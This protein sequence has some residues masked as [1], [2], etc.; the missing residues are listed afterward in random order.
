MILGER[1]LAPNSAHRDGVLEG[2]LERVEGLGLEL[3]P[4]QEE[5]ILELL[6]DHH[7]ILGTPTG[8][9]KSLVALALHFKALC[10]GQRSIYTAPTKALVAEK[11]FALSDELGAE[12]VG[13][14]TGDISL[15]RDAPVICATTEVLAN[16]VLRGAEEGRFPYVVLDEFHF[17]GDRER[18]VWW[19]IPLLA[20]PAATFLLL[21]A[22]LG[23]PTPLA[24]WL[25]SHTQRSVAAIV[26]T[27]RPVPLDFSYRETLLHE[28]VESLLEQSLD[29]I[30]LVCFTQ[31]A[32]AERA[33]ALTSARIGSRE[34]RKR[35]EAACGD[36]RFDTP[37]GRELRRLLGHGIGVHPAGLLPRY[38]LLV[39]QLAQ[40]GLLRVICGTDTLGVG[41]NI[42]IRTVLFSGL[43]K[44]DGEKITLLRARDFH[45]IAGR[46]GRKGFDEQG[47]VV[48]QAPEHV[49]WNRRAERKALGAGRRRKAR[50]KR[51][52]P[53]Q[54]VWNEKTFRSLVRRSPEPVVSH[55]RVT[56]GMLISLLQREAAE[57]GVAQGYRA[58][59]ELI[60]LSHGDARSRSR[61]LRDAADVFR[62]LLQAGILER[63]RDP[64]TGRRRVALDPG[65]QRN[66]S[67]HHALSLYLVE[68]VSALDPET[69]EYPLDVLSLI[70]A[71]LPDPRPILIQ[72]EKKARARKIAEL[73]AQRVPYHERL[74]Q[75]A[76]IHYPRPLED[77][78]EPTFETFARHHPW[79]RHENIHPKSVAREMFERY[80][81][82]EGYVR[83]YGLARSE[84]VLLRYLGQVYHALTRNV[85][86]GARSDSLLDVIRYFRT[87]LERIDASLLAE[88]HQVL[89][90]TRPDLV[91]ELEAPAESDLERDARTP[92]VRIRAEL[93]R[94]VAA[95]AARDW[96]A[97]AS[98]VRSDAP[99]PWSP[100]RFERALEPY[101]A[102]YS[103]I[104]FTPAARQPHRTEIRELGPGRWRVQQVLLDPAGD[105][106]WCIRGEVESAS[107]ADGTE[108]LLTL[109]AIGV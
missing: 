48:C 65:L 36:F 61:L 90:G 79:V 50:K 26:S 3:Y 33:Q 18:G 87:L 34:L 8:S 32:C 16:L 88:W 100:A 7:V 73:K 11:F 101:F 4:A 66:F 71:I 109:H 19:Q 23:D 21:S 72:Q 10:E 30:Y 39:E 43:S 63:K 97:A 31:R 15:N 45:Q 13:M 12:R 83:E 96:K 94:L 62:S 17:Y 1:I 41:V 76:G 80:A 75:I 42:P 95:L 98:A 92:A 35:V 29:P 74:E 46:A 20:M 104:L 103:E 60:G 106:L 77:F 89:H 44:F 86:E 99:E 27:E 78:I 91:G 53:G 85:P 22:T 58:L 102:E 105:E 49:I 37:Y 54:V 84:G 69:P 82:F 25:E 28:T 2:F 57:S 51:P 70:E 67:L 5:G 93:H 40:R 55:F 52:P 59:A 47:S 38:R 68:A 24:R 107:G 64:A 14:M 56:H 108:P 6:A 81:S 9:G